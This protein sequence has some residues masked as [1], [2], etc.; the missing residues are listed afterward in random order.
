MKITPEE[1]HQFIK[2]QLDKL[3]KEEIKELI[4]LIKKQEEIK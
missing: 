2:P 1:I 4:E 3:S